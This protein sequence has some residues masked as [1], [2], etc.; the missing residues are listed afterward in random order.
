MSKILADLYTL[1]Q[2]LR[3]ADDPVKGPAG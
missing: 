1:Q 3:L 2:Q